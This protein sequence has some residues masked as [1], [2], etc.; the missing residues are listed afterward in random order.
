MLESGVEDGTFAL[1]LKLKIMF[2]WVGSRYLHCTCCIMAELLSKADY[3]E[4][5]YG[6][7]KS[8]FSHPSSSVA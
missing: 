4:S 1:F 2:L 3:F 6:M 7:T 5:L 8:S